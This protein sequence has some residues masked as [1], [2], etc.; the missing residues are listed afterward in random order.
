[1]RRKNKGRTKD[2]QFKRDLDKTMMAQ[3]NWP[4]FSFFF[5][6]S[7]FVENWRKKKNLRAGLS[8]LRRF[9]LLLLQPWKLPLSPLPTTTR[10]LQ[11]KVP[12]PL[13]TLCRLRWSNL[14]KGLFDLAR[15]QFSSR[16][17]TEIQLVKHEKES[18]SFHFNA[19]FVHCVKVKRKNKSFF[20]YFHLAS[21]NL[22]F[23]ERALEDICV[24]Y[25]SSTH[26]F[27]SFGP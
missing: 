22:S 14:K 24:K 16:T 25:S 8:F 10:C 15:F 19:L 11:I 20:S 21:I 18:W 23:D 9:S 27:S 12:N 1:M 2:T 5:F 7:R 3:K 4:L 17:E 13:C 6:H 26:I